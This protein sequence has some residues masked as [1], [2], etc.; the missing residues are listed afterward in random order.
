LRQLGVDFDYSYRAGAVSGNAVRLPE[1]QVTTDLRTWPTMSLGMLGQHQAANAS[2]V[3]ATIERLRDAGVPISD[4][5]VIDGLAQVRCPARIEVVR[6]DPLVIVDCA[7]NVASAEALAATLRTTFADYMDLPK[8]GTGNRWLLFGASRDKDLAGILAV[9]APCF[10]QIY[11]TSYA[12]SRRSAS[13]RELL[14]ALVSTG[15]QAPAR[16]VSRAA[17]AWHE[18]EARA[19][20]DDLI[21]VTGSVF[22]AGEL[23]GLAANEPVA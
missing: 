16:Y 22:L 12:R 23:R 18:I 7:H 4:A 20:T 1:V 14:G 11:L 3:V 8:R 15:S 19:S 10:D 17:D 2:V 9:L 5:A 6:Q 21:C 13:E